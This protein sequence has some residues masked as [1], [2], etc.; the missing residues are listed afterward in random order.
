MDA[1]EE[2]KPKEGEGREEP[3]PLPL[4]VVT[5]LVSA[6]PDLR[7]ASPLPISLCRVFTFL[8]V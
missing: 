3:R 4:A 6:A 2:K 5:S 8:V 7:H 1:K